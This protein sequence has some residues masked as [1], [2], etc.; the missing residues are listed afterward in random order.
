MTILSLFFVLLAVISGASFYETVAVR[1]LAML[2]VVTTA[3]LWKG[4]RY[5]AYALAILVFAVLIGAWLP[6]DDPDSHTMLG[7]TA[8]VVGYAILL[9]GG[10]RWWTNGLPFITAQSAELEMERSQVREWVKV[11]NSSEGTD[12]VIEFSS[13]SFVRGYWTY[14]LLNTGFCWLIA[15]FKTGN[16]DRLRG[17]R[18]L[19]LDA[20]HV[21]N[22][23]GG[24]LHIVMGERTIQGVEI[25]AVMRDRLSHLVSVKS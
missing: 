17:C 19:G 4:S 15:K 7:A 8:N 11:L 16:M 14:R 18:V 12:K 23:P 9:F 22:Q 13:K 24:K 5:A 3:M 2:A 6:F 10:Y 25:S 20:V 21:T 1:V